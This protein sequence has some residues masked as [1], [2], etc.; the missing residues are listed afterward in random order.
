MPIEDAALRTAPKEEGPHAR[1]VVGRKLPAGIELE[2]SPRIL[3]KEKL[4]VGILEPLLLFGREGIRKLGTLPA[5]HDPQVV[6][7]TG[8]PAQLLQI[9]HERHGS[10]PG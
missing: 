5:L 3:E 8:M 4:P 6:L 9:A 1:L 10:I 2:A 7:R